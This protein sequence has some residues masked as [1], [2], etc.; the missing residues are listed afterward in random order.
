MKVCWSS[1]INGS[2]KELNDVDDTLSTIV[3]NSDTVLAT[4]SNDGGSILGLA[5]EGSDDR[6]I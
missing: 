2:I 1:N 4:V 6:S 3:E 5:V